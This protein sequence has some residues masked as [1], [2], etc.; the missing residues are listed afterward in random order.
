[1]DNSIRRI[2]VIVPPGN[3][4]VE[5]EFP[6]HLPPGIV[7]NHNRLSRPDNQQTP[8]SILAMNDSLAQTARDLSQAY[9]E[10]IAYVCTGGSFLEGPGN[11]AKPARVI[12]EATGVPAISTSIS[13]VDALHVFGIRKVLLVGPYP[14]PIMKSEVAFLQFYGFEV[15]EYETF[16]CATSEANRALTSDQ[17]A[18]RVLDRRDLIDEC[19]GV[20]VSCTNI[21]VMDQIERLEQALGKPVVTSNQATL[22]DVLRR[23]KVD[24]R[25]L[26][27]GR[28]FEEHGHQPA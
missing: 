24:S 4:A 7:L 25:G 15:P 12:E 1:M 22:W 13:V 26:R 16:D 21:L 6:L 27:G 28:L 20:F 23:M 8:E 3:V 19:D 18:Q 5:R 2:G 11:E 14:H 10:V 9:P 17:I